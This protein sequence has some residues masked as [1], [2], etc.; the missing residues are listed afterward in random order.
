M[1]T[2]TR[3][4]VWWKW[5]KT[6]KFI[7]NVDYFFP[8]AELEATLIN[9][10]IQENRKAHK[11]DE[12]EIEQLI[13]RRGQAFDL[14]IKFNREYQPDRDAFALLFITGKALIQYL[15]TVFR[16]IGNWVRNSNWVGGQQ[17]VIASGQQSIASGNN[18]GTAFSLVHFL[19][20]AVGTVAVVD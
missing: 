18:S 12:Y 6:E 15:L 14:T 2:S 4:A 13:L 19:K 8:E 9:F 10:H 1:Q 7:W 16:T 3:A 11:T 5:W 20:A 17:E